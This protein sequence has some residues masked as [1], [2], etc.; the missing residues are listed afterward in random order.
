MPNDVNRANTPIILAV[1]LNPG[2]TFSVA[3]PHNLKL[4]PLRKSFIDEA[5]RNAIIY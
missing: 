4:M 3:K 2:V 5:F 1:K